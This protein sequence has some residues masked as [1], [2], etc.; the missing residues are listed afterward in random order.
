MKKSDLQEKEAIAVYS[1]TNTAS[2][3]ILEIDFLEERVYYAVSG[4]K[5]HPVRFAKLRQTK[6]GHEYFNSFLGRIDMLECMAVNQ[7]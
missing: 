7:F 1:L 4:E 6:E 3:V 2:I 5:R